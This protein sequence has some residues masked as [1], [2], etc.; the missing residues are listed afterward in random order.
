MCRL[1]ISADSGI[2]TLFKT[3]DLAVGISF[4]T[5]EQWM[6]Q[7]LRL[8]QKGRGRTSPN[9]VVGALVVKGG[10]VVGQG[11]HARAGEPHAEIL[12]LQQAG[13][14]A[15][16]ATLY[17]N[18]E[19][20]S[21]YGR[22]PPCAPR[23]IEAQVKKVVI[24]MEDPNPLVKGKGIGSM[25]Q[26]GLSVRMGVLEK[27]CQTVNEAFCKFI[28]EKEPFVILKVASTLDG[29]IATQ[30]GDSK[31][32]T[33]EKSRRFVHGLRDQVDGVLVGIGTVLRDDPLL[34]ARIRGGRD[35]YRIVLDSRL[36][37]KE[38]ARVF[39]KDPS[40]VILCTT[41][42]GSK[43]KMARLEKRGVQILIVDAKHQRIDLK[44]CLGRLGA[45]GIMT[46]LVEGGSKVNGSFLDERLVDKFY[47]FLSPK[48]IGDQEA[49]G[50]FGG[51]GIKDLREVVTLKDIRARRV[52]EDFLLEGYLVK[53][54]DPCSQGL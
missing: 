30:G 10:K 15:R 23:V 28:I 31:W 17:V 26:A 29:K 50:I 7:V 34:T 48:W 9:P 27:E 51:H 35:P 21:H 43:D 19:P 2:Q 1:K 11:Y 52:G 5:D 18:L 53:G 20:C 3:Y 37:I 40:Q 14:K 25:R 13:E 8:A 22:T 39:G 41:Q 4:M 24:G 47:F 33:G 46:L 36:R 16:G 44:A 12:A 45:M 49:P 54:S 32:I 42:E 6:R 38:G